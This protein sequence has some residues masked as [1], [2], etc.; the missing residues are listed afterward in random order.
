M[1]NRAKWE[2]GSTVKSSTITTPVLSA[3]RIFLLL[4][5]VASSDCPTPVCAQSLVPSDVKN[6]T[7]GQIIKPGE[8]L[9]VDVR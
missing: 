4:F 3:A 9:H 7:P 6:D 1:W 2:A 5:C 8:F